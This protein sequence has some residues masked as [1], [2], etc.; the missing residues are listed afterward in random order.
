MVTRPH[1]EDLKRRYR[2]ADWV[3]EYQRL[4]AIF[5]HWL[6]TEAGQAK[7]RACIETLKRRPQIL[8]WVENVISQSAYNYPNRVTDGYGGSYPRFAANNEIS[9]FFRAIESSPVVAQRIN[10]PWRPGTEAHVQQS[11]AIA[12]T[13]DQFRDAYDAHGAALGSRAGIAYDETLHQ[14]LPALGVGATGCC[15]YRIAVPSTTTPGSC[16]LEFSWTLD[17]ERVLAEGVSR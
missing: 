6:C 13:R 3:S 12:L 16:A 10:W 1:F 8:T 2:E 4:W 7:D 15:F 11:H 17:C 5:N 14:V 9:R